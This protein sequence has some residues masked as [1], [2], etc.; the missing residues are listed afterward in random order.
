MSFS[1][2]KQEEVRRMFSNLQVLQMSDA[3]IAEHIVHLNCTTFPPPFF[4]F[5]FC[6]D[7]SRYCSNIITKVSTQEYGAPW[8]CNLQSRDCSQHCLYDSVVVVADDSIVEL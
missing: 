1:E 5:D 3:A 4:S 6:T 2:R 7:G 8:I